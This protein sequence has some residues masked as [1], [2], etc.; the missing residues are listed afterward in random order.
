MKDEPLF[1]FGQGKRQNPTDGMDE[2]RWLLLYTHAV[3]NRGVR[4]NIGVGEG[5]GARLSNNIARQR[6]E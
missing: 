4:H 6:L 3:E 5:G 1:D 2:A